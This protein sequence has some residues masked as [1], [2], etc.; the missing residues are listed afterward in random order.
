MIAGELVAAGMLIDRMPAVRGRLRSCVR[1]RDLTWLRVGGPAEVMFRPADME[2]LAQLCGGLPENVPVTAVGVGSNLLV[3]DGGVPGVVVRLGGP[4]ARVAGEGDDLVVGAGALDAKVSLA[5]AERGLS[6]L[7]FLSG[8]PG[9]IGGALRM[10]AGAYGRE[11]RDIIVSAEAMDRAGEV[12]TLNCEELGFGYRSSRVP[13]SWIFVGATLRGEPG[14]KAEIT[15]RMAEIRKAR[16]TSQPVRARTGG[17]T[18]K[19]VG[20]R[21][22]WKLVRDAGGAGLS[23]GAAKVSEQH[24]N[25]LINTGNAT[26]ADLEGLAL[27]VAEKVHASSGV[28]LEWEIRRIGAAAGQ[29]P[30]DCAGAT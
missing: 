5:A 12:H 30:A 28:R 3:R 2:D 26:A 14:K 16:E 9:T 21:K 27:E 25:F 1:L 4:F 24:A 15:S 6:G 7:E 10:N 23:R 17:S 11:M 13:E 29:G 8:V 19:N 18:F 22:A 20:L